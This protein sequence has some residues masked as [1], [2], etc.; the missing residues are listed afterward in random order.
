MMD[1][2]QLR[3]TPELLGVMR[4]SVAHA[5]EHAASFVTPAHLMLG[6]LAEPHVGEAL[7]GLVPRERVRG[8]AESGAV[9]LPGVVEVPEGAIPEGEH[10]PFV[11]F[12]TL[13][14]RSPDGTRTLY[15]DHDAFRVFIEGARRAAETYQPKDLVLGF[16]AE[17]LKDQE[18]LGFLGSDPERVTAAIAALP[19]S[20]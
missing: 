18:I 4:T 10:P 14:F 11:R 13:A 20:P 15:L 16:V 7:R 17:A 19:A 6:L 2:E 9:R 8:A 3:L 1:H 5:I 12:D